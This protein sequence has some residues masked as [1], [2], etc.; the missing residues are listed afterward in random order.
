[1]SGWLKNRTTK[2]KSCFG[3]GGLADNG[4]LYRSGMNS[5]VFLK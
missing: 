3:E 4:G 2:W 5:L 1:M